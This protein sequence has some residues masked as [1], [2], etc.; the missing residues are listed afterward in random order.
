MRVLFVSANESAPWGPSETNW[1][2]AATHWLREGAEVHAS[3]RG[4]DELPDELLAVEKAGCVVHRRWEPAPFDQRPV[5][6]LPWSERQRSTLELVRPDLVVVSQGDNYEGLGWMEECARR[7]YPYVAYAN[8]AAEHEWLPDEV[9]ERLAKGYAGA[10]ASMFVSERN[11]RLTEDQ[12]GGPIENARVVRCHFR[13]SYD[14]APPWPES[15]E[16]LRLACV[17]RLDPN[18]K[19]QDVLF[20]V[21]SRPKWRQRPVRVTLFGSGPC[22]RVLLALRDRLELSSVDFAGH[23]AD[24]EGIWREHHALVLC[25]RAEGLPTVIIEAML[26]GRPVI[27]S[28]VAGN[29]ELV[30]DDVTGFVAAGPVVACLDEAM[31]RAWRNRDRLREMGRL[32]AYSVREQ[33]PP[34]PIALLVDQLAE[35][36]P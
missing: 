34:D 18:D 25:S 7:G 13:V 5:Y 15:D 32:A 8:S 16:P 29:T 28:D 24:V 33:V 27:V 14:A 31:E 26:C 35:L 21:L 2:L 20:D 23:T 1:A 4:W 12:V 3:V 11:L 30:A 19:G 22:E 6:E 17:A 10:R 36:V 9:A